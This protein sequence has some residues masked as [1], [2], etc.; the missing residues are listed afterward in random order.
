MIAVYERNKSW[1]KAERPW[2]CNEFLLANYCSRL[3]RIATWKFDKFSQ[4]PKRSF[5]EFANETVTLSLGCFSQF[6]WL[7]RLLSLNAA[8]F[9][10]GA[11]GWKMVMSKRQGLR[12]RWWSPAWC[13]ICNQNGPSRMILQ[14]NNRLT[15]FFALL[16]E[17]RNTIC[18]N[19]SWQ[20]PEVSLPCFCGAVVVHRPTCWTAS[21]S[22]QRKPQEKF[23]FYVPLYRNTRKFAQR[24]AQVK[25]TGLAPRGQGK[26]FFRTLLFLEWL[27]PK[28]RK[29]PCSL[30]TK[31]IPC[32]QTQIS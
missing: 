7:A 23:L 14:T 31:C 10:P 1:L 29:W 15:L 4:D 9:H 11:L 3:A 22:E 17:H 18:G 28:F 16:T 32:R 2:R 25:A 13:Q 30:Y 21:I 19:A 8:I 5:V 24:G 27:S 12:V 6:P 20:V 26:H